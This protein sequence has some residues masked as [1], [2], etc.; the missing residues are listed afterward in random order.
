[1]IE[2]I[3]LTIVV[4]VIVV[5]IHLVPEA[6]MYVATRPLKDRPV[7]EKML[8]LATRIVVAVVILV[9]LSLVGWSIWTN[10]FGYR[11]LYGR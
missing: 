6:F 7:T 9:L 1:M 2:I 11:E 8:I 4:F 10:G 5:A 3:A